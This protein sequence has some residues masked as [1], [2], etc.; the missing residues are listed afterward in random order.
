MD[1]AE[2][3]PTVTVVEPLKSL[4]ASWIVVPPEIEPVVGVTELRFGGVTDRSR[5]ETVLPP[6]LAT[7]A[8]FPAGA[9]A[10]P[11]GFEPTS[12]TPTRRLSERRTFATALAPPSVNNA[13]FESEVTA[14]P[15]DALPS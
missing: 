4:P 11:S 7:Y 6:P 15:I 5:I 9:T 13:K 14:T 3:S 8:A 2:T 12:M 1:V 10:R